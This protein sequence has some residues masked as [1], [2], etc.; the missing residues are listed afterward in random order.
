MK[1]ICLMGI[2][3]INNNDM[4]RVATIE[5]YIT[6]SVSY[7]HNKYFYKSTLSFEYLLKFRYEAGFTAYV[8][9]RANLLRGQY[10][11]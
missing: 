11:K 2:N 10:D 3:M 1:L 7:K 5:Y 6:N 9:F 8:P 4:V